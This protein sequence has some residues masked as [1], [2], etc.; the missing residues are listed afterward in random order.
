[1]SRK[2]NRASNISGKAAIVGIGAS[3]FTK[4][5]GKTELRMTCECIKEALDDAGLVPP[6]IDGIVKHTDDA[7]DEHSVI[8]AM[9]MGNLT[10]FGECR[11]DGAS[12][13]MVMRAAIGVATG[14]AN[15]I[16]IYRAVNGSSKR[17]MGT[18]TRNMEQMATGDLIKWTFH[19]P[20]GLISETGRI[21]MI[22]RTYMNEVGAKSEQI[23]WVTAVCREHG[24]KNPNGIFY[25]KPIT[26]EDY[27]ASK[28]I[29]DPIRLMD[30]YEEADGAVAMVVTTA[31]RAKDLRQKPALILGAAQSIV[32]ETEE[33]N[34][35]YRKDIAGLPEI[36]HMG[37]KLF[38]M[39]HVAPKDI[40]V[41]ELDD[42]YAPLV[43]M[44]LE[45]LGFCSRGDGAAFCEGGSKIRDGGEVVINTSGGSLGEGYLYGMNHVVEA[46]RQI[47]GKAN[48]QVKNADLA[49][50]AAGAGGPA[51]GLILG[52]S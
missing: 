5:S 10:Y 16:V 50:V 33:K 46:V 51:S 40:K 36:G 35:Y 8:N 7:T 18:S 6:D 47:R 44:Q 17:R 12:C 32:A 4:D 39:A 24:A 14:M 23:G 21:A 34:G 3:N 42:T 9:G 11:W 2:M 15:Y 19:A 45:E 49:L 20:F 38:Q 28:M 41:A 25:R 52:G 43:P 27:L 26:I 1:M 37:R 29:V 22:V 31:E 13:G 48:V 30:C